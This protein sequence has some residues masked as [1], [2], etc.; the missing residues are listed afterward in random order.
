MNVDT[1]EITVL[2]GPEKTKSLAE[3]LEDRMVPVSDVVVQQMAAGDV[4]LNRAERRGQGWRCSCRY[5]NPSHRD[6]CSVCGLAKPV[7]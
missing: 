7:G 3:L 6:R 2:T 4:A 1:G 5:F